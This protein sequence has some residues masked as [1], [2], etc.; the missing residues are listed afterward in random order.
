[1]VILSLSESVKCMEILSLSESVK[2]ME[3]LSVLYYFNNFMNLVL[4]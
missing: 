1:M 2:C 4:P 3:I